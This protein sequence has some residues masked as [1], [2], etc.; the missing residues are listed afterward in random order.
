[1][2]YSTED[3]KRITREHEEF[4]VWL[5]ERIR[6]LIDTSIYEVNY[7]EYYE[8]QDKFNISWSTRHDNESV[9]IDWAELADETNE[10]FKAAQTERDRIKAEKADQKNRDLVARQLSAARRVYEDAVTRAKSMGIEEE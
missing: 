3:A 4:L 10:T 7:V 1:M 8:N 5:E 9:T 6:V 2:T